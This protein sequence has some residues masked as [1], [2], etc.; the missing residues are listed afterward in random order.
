MVTLSSILSAVRLWYRAHQ[1]LR[2]LGELDDRALKDFGISRCE[3][4]S[5]VAGLPRTV[6][7]DFLRCP[8]HD[9]RASGPSAGFH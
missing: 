1:A 4:P 5:A 2:Q 3:I 6:R 7:S 9:R 8:K